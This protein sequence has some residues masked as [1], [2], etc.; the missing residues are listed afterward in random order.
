M[1]ERILA[2]WLHILS[3]ENASDRELAAKNSAIVKSFLSHIDFLFPLCLKSLTLRLSK[4][5]QPIEVIPS[6]FLDADHLQILS[7][8]FLRIANGLISSAKYNIM[9]T[10][11]DSVLQ[12]VLTQCD[13]VVDFITGLFAVI[14]PQQ[15]SQLVL[16]FIRSLQ[17]AEDSYYVLE[18]NSDDPY[19]F[20]GFL[21]CCRQLRIR[22]FERL[23]SLPNFVAVNFPYK[24]NNICQTESVSRLS[25]IEQSIPNGFKS[26]IMDYKVPKRHWL[27]D[28]VIEDCISIAQKTSETILNGWIPKQKTN[29][30]AK[31]KSAASSAFRQRIPLSKDLIKHE[32]S[33]AHN[34]ISIIYDILLRKNAL[35]LRYQ[36]KEAF[37]RIVAMF[38]SPLILGTTQAVHVLSKMD[39]SHKLRNQ[40]LLCVLCSIQEAPDAA[41]RNTIS[42]LC[43]QDV[44]FLQLLR[45]DFLV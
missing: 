45:L 24:Y 20:M 32:E 16:T 40:W 4:S 13:F 14:H 27:A 34:A 5:K 6:A 10:D 1:Y 19:H 2:V 44:S 30:S 37:E 7:A 3:N 25:W 39:P 28:L 23:V 31:G 12:T 33:I 42:S 17:D 18:R 38:I 26:P 8:L 43:S 36:R 21:S 22:A 29:K 15:V 11:F 41:L 35:D 9:D